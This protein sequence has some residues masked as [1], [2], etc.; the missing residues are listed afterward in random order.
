MCIR[1]SD[2]TVS[3]LQDFATGVYE[4]DQ[5]LGELVDYFSDVD[6]PTIIVFWGDHYNP[7]GTGYEVFEKTGYID[8]GDTTSPNL[9]QTD[10]LIWSNYY[11]EPIDLGTVAAY[12]T[13]PEMCIRDRS[14]PIR[15][16]T[17]LLRSGLEL[18]RRKCLF[19]NWRRRKS[20]SLC[21]R[22]NISREMCIRDRLCTKYYLKF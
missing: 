18:S 8:Q 19:R 7:L 1:D 21:R 22:K 9:R 14:C 11:K 15:I 16:E 20:K 13:S 5:A 17:T 10:L 3:Q 2:N 12:E 4:A 6:E